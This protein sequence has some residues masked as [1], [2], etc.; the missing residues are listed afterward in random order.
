M[1]YEAQVAGLP[2]R[3]PFKKILTPVL[4]FV[5]SFSAKRAAKIR[6]DLRAKLEA[7]GFTIETFNGGGTGSLSFNVNE[8]DVLTEVTAGSGLYCPHLFDYYS[9]FSMKPACF[10]ALPTVRQPSANWLTC[11]G[12]GFIASGEPGWDRVPRPVN[13]NIA[14]SNFEACGE[15]QTPVRVGSAVQLG[16]AIL[17]RHAKAGELLERFNDVHLVRGNEIQETVKSYRGLGR[18]YF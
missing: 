2:D 18:C 3:N 13:R 5:R 12:G 15:V 8:S 9:N 4:S 10:F 1:A 17:F 11:L 16:E 7:D 14:L 6:K